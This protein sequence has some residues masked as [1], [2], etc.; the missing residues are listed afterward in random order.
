L[1]ENDFKTLENLVKLSQSALH[2]TMIKYLKT[3]YPKVIYTKEYIA[4]EG[5]IPIALVAHMD[6]VFKLLPEEVFFD[7]RYNVMWS[8]D[9]LGADDRAGIFAIFQIIKSGLR[10]HIILTT[11]EE[12]GGFGANAI[13]RA[14][15]PFKDLRYIIELDRRGTSDCVFYD[16]DNQEFEQY[17][18]NFGFVTA[19]GTFS[20]ISI[21][22]PSWGVAGVNLSIGYRDE[23]SPSE[24]LFIN[25][26]IN[27]IERVKTMLSQTDIPFFK[28]IPAARSY[29]YF[30]KDWFKGTRLYNEELKCDKCGKYFLEEEMFPVHTKEGKTINVCSECVADNVSWCLH[31]HNA[32]ESNKDSSVIDICDACAKKNT[33]E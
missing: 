8:P 14:G 30:D 13:A 24:V 12:I 6:T 26:M 7:P 4:A 20:D 11:D 31:C 21:I 33:G 29:N 5:D 22:C 18:E 23:H 15:N 16:C 32:F 2:S 25:A 9:G 10:P 28:Y 19:W 1:K 3:K 27:T 17:I